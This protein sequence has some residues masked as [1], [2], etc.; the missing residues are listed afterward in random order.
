MFDRVL[1]RAG[2][3]TRLA[4]SGVEALAVADGPDRIDLLVTD[5]MMPEMNGDEVARRL[6][7]KYPA[8]KVLYCT[9]FSDRLFDQ[10]GSAVGGRSVHR[11]A[12][13]ARRRCSRPCRSFAITTNASAMMQLEQTPA[14]ATSCPGADRM[15]RILLVDDD[16]AVL[17][18]LT[19][20]LPGYELSVARD[21]GEAWVTAG[22]L[23]KPDLLITDY[24]MPI[25]SG[26]ELIGRL[27]K[28]WPDLK[29][30]V[31]TGHAES[32]ESDGPAWWRSEA[33][34]AKPFEP[35]TLRNTVAALMADQP[36]CVGAGSVR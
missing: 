15:K 33:H 4:S 8:L 5:M 17:E 25:L 13:H 35:Q 24:M 16:A 32:L 28:S 3:I 9:G 12:V 27:R 21:G 18:V 31:L 23:G 10:K 20:S 11:E 26:D 19:R 14:P 29:V 6:R 1:K 30:L 36:E 7:Q 22:R 2:Y 34:L